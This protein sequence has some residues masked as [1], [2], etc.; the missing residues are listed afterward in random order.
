MCICMYC[1]LFICQTQAESQVPK[2][3]KKKKKTKTEDSDSGVEVYFR[4]EEDKE[5]EEEPKPDPVKVGKFTLLLCNFPFLQEWYSNII[6]ILIMQILNNKCSPSFSQQ[7][8]PSSAGPSRLQVA[9]GFSW[10]IGLNS[11][12]PVSAMKDADSSDGED[13]EGSSKV[14]Q[15]GACIMSELL[16]EHYDLSLCCVC[17]SN[18][19]SSKSLYFICL[20]LLSHLT[21]LCRLS[22]HASSLL[23]LRQPQKKS[24]HELEQEKK[25]AEKALVQRETELMDPNLRPQDAAAF[26]RLLLASPNSSL[27]WLQYMAHHLQATQ[28]EQARAVAERA[29]KTISFR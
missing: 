10:D 25:A 5:D 28:I 11:L 14:S 18:M 21:I 22:H 27:L 29:L 24:R 4:E 16:T 8:T 12:K 13:Q 1:L 9:A 15:Q 20:F 2:Q 3:K 6:T 26:E 23:V 17:R 19:I 7:V